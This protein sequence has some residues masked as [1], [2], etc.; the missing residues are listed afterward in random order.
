MNGIVASGRGG[1]QRLRWLLLGGGRAGG[2]GAG[3]GRAARGV[4]GARRRAACRRM[5]VPGM[6]KEG[7]AD[8]D[9]ALREGVDRR[10]GSLRRFALLITLRSPSS[11]PPRPSPHQPAAEHLLLL[12]T[13]HRQGVHRVRVGGRVAREGEGGFA[14]NLLALSS[15]RWTRTGRELRSSTLYLRGSAGMDSTD[16]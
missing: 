13:R 12:R 2:G 7:R 11:R 14:P 16:V 8:D 9:R 6:L 15:R 10:Q 4:V 1:G 3:E 5:R